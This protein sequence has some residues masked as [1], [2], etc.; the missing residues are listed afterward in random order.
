MISDKFRQMF[1]LPTE[2]LITPASDVAAL[3]E[4]DSLFHAMLVLSSSGYQTIPVLDEED[5]VRGLISISMIVTKLEGIDAFDEDKLSIY[6][7]KDVMSQVVPILFD[8]FDLEDVLRLAID[9]NF[10]CI[11]Y[12]DG[13]FLGIVTR[14][15]VLERFTYIAHNVDKYYDEKE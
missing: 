2:N 13:Y 1:F 15:T 8:D 6:K 12:R 5:R 14:K 11:T 7:V 3:R 10:I 4:E 9:N